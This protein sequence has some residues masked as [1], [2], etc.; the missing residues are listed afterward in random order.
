MTESSNSQKPLHQNCSKIRYY[1]ACFISSLPESPIRSYDARIPPAVKRISEY[2]QVTSL[3]YF[4]THICPADF[5]ILINMTSPFPNLGVWCNFIFL[6]DI[7]V[8]KQCRP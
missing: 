1:K 7:P 4:L 5:S 3:P 6:L 2:Q 8:S